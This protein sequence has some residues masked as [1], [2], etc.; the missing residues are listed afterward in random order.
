IG[1]QTY[2][3]ADRSDKIKVFVSQKPEYDDANQ[4]VQCA[5]EDVRANVA[6]NHRRNGAHR[7]MRDHAM[8]FR[9]K[10]H[11]RAMTMFFRSQHEIDEKGN[12]PDRQ[13]R[14][15]NHPGI[16]G[17]HPREAGWFLNFHGDRLF[18]APR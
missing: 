11:R 3:T 10:P 16:L 2:E 8:S 15:E 5:D 6:P 13:H 17:Y 7:T 18:A 12:E 9:K 4:S 14:L 1:N